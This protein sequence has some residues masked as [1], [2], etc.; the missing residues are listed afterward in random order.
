ML[1]PLRAV[2]FTGWMGLA[3]IFDA[4]LTVLVFMVD[5]CPDT[6]SS[7]RRISWRPVNFVIP[8]LSLQKSSKTI[9]I[10]KNFYV[11]PTAMGTSPPAPGTNLPCLRE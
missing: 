11:T 8:V 3:R 9:P 6:I 1:S 2:P 5:F 10:Q 4:R 7:K